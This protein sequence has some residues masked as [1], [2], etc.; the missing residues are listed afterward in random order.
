[1]C[2]FLTVLVL[3]GPRFAGI[4]WWIWQPLRWATTF[5]DSW[6]IPLLGLIFLP[7]TTLFA[8]IVG[9]NGIAGID[10]LFIALGFIFDLGSYTGGGYG[11]RDRIGY[12]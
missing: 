11:N 8:V 3:L 12:S 5:N 1:M 7:W 2:C 9:W 6:I 10:W 4:V